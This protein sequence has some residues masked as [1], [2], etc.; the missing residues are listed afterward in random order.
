M[1]EIGVIQTWDDESGTKH[2]RTIAAYRVDERNPKTEPEV[3]QPIDGRTLAVVMKLF[4]GI[5][6]DHRAAAAE[7]GDP[8]ETP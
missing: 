5:V 1:I 6:R 8:E 7:F 4:R 2:S 3:L